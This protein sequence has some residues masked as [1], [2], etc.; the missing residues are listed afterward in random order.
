[1]MITWDDLYD[2]FCKKFPNLCKNAVRY[3]PNGYMSIIVY[4]KDGSK[5]VYDSSTQRTRMMAV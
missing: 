2:E 4:F 3:V 1:M 5:A